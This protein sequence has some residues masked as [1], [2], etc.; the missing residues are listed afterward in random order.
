MNIKKIVNTIVLIGI[1]GFFLYLSIEKT[2]FGL[3]R[4]HVNEINIWLLMVGLGLLAA[5]YVVRGRRWQVYFL[6]MHIPVTFWHSL[7]TL[8]MGFAANNVLPLRA[9]EVYR[10]YA[11]HTLYPDVSIP[12]AFTTVVVER[13]LD[14]ITVVFFTL[15]GS[16]FLPMPQWA[17][18]AV[19][20]ASGIF[21]ALF[22]LFI[23]S[24]KYPVKAQSVVH[25]F[26]VMLPKRIGD[27][28]NI[29]SKQ[30]FEGLRALN[31]FPSIFRL[32]GLSLLVWGLEVLFYYTSFHAFGIQLSLG[33][34]AFLM[35]IINLAIVI[36]AS[37]GGVGTYEYVTVLS[38]SLMGVNESLSFLFAIVTHFAANITVIIFGALFW[39]TLEKEKH[40]VIP[41]EALK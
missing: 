39:Y 29:F 28:V 34:A 40:L 8:V 27:K 37:P 26:S 17:T 12:K 6:L 9:G 36:P 25:T 23:V 32:M 30:L 7:K 24:A 21:G 10:A 33:F 4:S 15:V 19:E 18:Q 35:G 41:K 16:L 31:S 5:G 3:M 14:G 1:S 22:V 11:L 38:F 13:V 20:V 2:D